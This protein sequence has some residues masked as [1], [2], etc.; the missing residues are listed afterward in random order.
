MGI[1]IRNS[2]EHDYLNSM[3]KILIVEDDLDVAGMIEDWLVHHE[4][5]VVEKVATGSDAADRLKFY[6]YDL[7]ILDWELPDLSG[8]E[9][10]KRYRSA[11]GLVPILMLTGK[12]AIDEKELGLDSGADD[13]LTKPFEG[14][15]LSARIRALLRRSSGRA[16][17]T[18]KAHDVL[19][20]PVSRA[21]T[22]AGEPIDLLPKEFALLE[23]FLRHPDEVF[24]LEALLDRVWKSES[25]SSPDTVR[26]TIQRLRKKID[27]E[28]EPS[29]IG[30]I[31]RVG[32]H[33]VREKK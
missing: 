11:D 9:I 13:Y 31:H 1:R 15:E 24:S 3:A 5:H 22:K 14:K 29:L 21:V 10:L 26:T 25:D 2:L 27:R 16:T 19:L 20:D 28:G 23:F 18:L 32:Y 33:L 7:I 12:S 17:N 4:K 8:I 6:H 30:T